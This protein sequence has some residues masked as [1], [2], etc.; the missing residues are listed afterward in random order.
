MLNKLLLKL[1]TVPVVF[2]VEYINVPAK[3]IVPINDVS[4]HVI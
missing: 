2:S 4:E 1:S 3:W